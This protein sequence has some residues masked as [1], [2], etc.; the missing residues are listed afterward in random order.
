MEPPGR[1]A[2][3]E[4][5][6]TIAQIFNPIVESGRHTAFD[7]RFTAEAGRDLVP[8]LPPRRVCHVAVRINRHVKSK[9]VDEILI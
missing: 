5:A 4:N 7:T 8:D 9:C 6:E 3:V 2:R 1:D